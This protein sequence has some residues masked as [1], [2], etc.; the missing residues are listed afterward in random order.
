MSD[1]YIISIL[2][3]KFKN[4]LQFNVNHVLMCLNKKN[5]KINN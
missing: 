3:T 4:T 2:F 5:V 1:L